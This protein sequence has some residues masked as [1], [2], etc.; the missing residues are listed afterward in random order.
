MAFQP[1][2]IVQL[3]R[4]GRVDRQLSAEPPASVTSGDVLVEHGPTDA[5]GRLEAPAAG[6]VVLSLLSPEALRHEAKEVRRVIA[7]A[8]TGTEPLLVDVEAGEELRVEELA[9]LLE[10]ARH[11]SRAVILRIVGD[12]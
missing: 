4:D 8:G 2:L 3:P 7:Q 1:L 10:A 11:S 5:D 9:P 6:Q 12:A